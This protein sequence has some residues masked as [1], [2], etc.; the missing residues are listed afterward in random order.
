M[1]RSRPL[2]SAHESL[3]CGSVALCCHASVWLKPEIS[4]PLDTIWGVF[5]FTFV[6]RLF[7]PP[8]Q[9]WLR[10]MRWRAA[11]RS[12]SALQAPCPSS[13]WHPRQ[14]D[15]VFSSVPLTVSTHSPVMTFP[16]EHTRLSIW[17]RHKDSQTK[18]FPQ[19]HF[20]F[21]HRWPDEWF[22]GVF[23]CDFA[24]WNAPCLMH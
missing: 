16:T 13:R 4:D 5:F 14:V 19:Q 20:P 24:V 10:P 15:A 12:S 18:N 2:R 8:Y 3:R 23:T 17:R 22:I 21:T 9:W 7:P 1:D 6:E 11:S